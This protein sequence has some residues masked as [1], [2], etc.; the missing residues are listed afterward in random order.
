M[1][2]TYTQGPR[3]EH[4]PHSGK[5]LGGSSAINFM[6]YLRPG[7]EDFDGELTA[8]MLVA[9][10]NVER[11]CAD[12]ERLGNPG[13]NYKHFNRLCAKFEG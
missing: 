3:A 10:L 12:I 7:K 4:P 9:T 13:W 8:G 2:F 11:F 5:G 1:Y 6:C